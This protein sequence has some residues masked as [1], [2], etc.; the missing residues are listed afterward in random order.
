MGDRDQV[1]SRLAD[2]HG[3]IV[4]TGKDAFRAVDA[5]GDEVLEAEAFEILLR[6]GFPKAE[7]PDVMIGGNE[8]QVDAGREAE[9]AETDSRVDGLGL[10]PRTNW[11]KANCS[12]D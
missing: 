9:A 6:R 10:E 12:T 7:A 1:E 3:E 4:F 2:S 5:G 11:L 8:R